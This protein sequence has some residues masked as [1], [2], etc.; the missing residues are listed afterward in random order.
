MATIDLPA[1]NAITDDHLLAAL[2]EEVNNPDGFRFTD[3]YQVTYSGTGSHVTL[4]ALL[5]KDITPDVGGTQDTT[6]AV[7]I[8]ASF[9]AHWFN[10]EHT[11]AEDAQQFTELSPQQ[12]C[13]MVGYLA[14]HASPE[15][16]GLVGPASLALYTRHLLTVLVE[17][18]EAEAMPRVVD[19]PRHW[20]GDPR[21][22]DITATAPDGKDLIRL[23]VDVKAREDLGW[24]FTTA[25]EFP[26][27][28]MHDL[29]A[30][31]LDLGSFLSEE[32][33]LIEHHLDYGSSWSN[34][35][36]EVT[37][38]LLD[39]PAPPDREPVPG[40]WVTLHYAG[41]DREEALSGQPFLSHEQAEAC[42]NGLDGYQ[43]FTHTAWVAADALCA[44][45]GVQPA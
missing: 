39:T 9:I 28:C 14:S 16:M 11:P 45:A 19:S 42:V 18:N 43:L 3:R 4:A 33:D 23:H 2:G 37:A 30:G 40:V 24:D 25:I 6:R 41:R 27:A 31:G 15:N 44:P 32:R 20:L 26:V 7:R 34:N 38:K 8:A 12:V 22:L 17:G 13:R 1:A 5:R 35:G 10:C 29:M 36:L 21:D